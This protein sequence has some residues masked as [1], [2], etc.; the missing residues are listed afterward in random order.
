VESESLPEIVNSV[1]RTRGFGHL[2]VE[3]SEREDLRKFAEAAASNEDL[4]SLLAAVAADHSL[5]E[6]LRAIMAAPGLAGL[7]LEI[8]R[9]TDLRALTESAASDAE[10]FSAAAALVADGS[11]QEIVRSASTAP[12]L[13]ELLLDISRRDDLTKLTE[14]LSANVALADAASELVRAKGLARGDHSHRQRRCCRRR[15]LSAGYKRSGA[16]V[17]GSGGVVRIVAVRQ[18]NGM[19]AR[20]L[21]WLLGTG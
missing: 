1:V 9:R 10:L 16:R 14:A 13:A 11:L 4:F 17:A 18:A 2:L 8:T 12:G 19:T 3:L 5:Q 21:N 20:I 15:R 6:I 7:L